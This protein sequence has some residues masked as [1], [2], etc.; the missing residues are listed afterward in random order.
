M[1]EQQ[2]KLHKYFHN[3]MIYFAMWAYAALAILYGIRHILSVL[4][5]GA[6]HLALDIILSVLLIGVG[7]ITIKAR[8]DLAAFRIIVIKELLG[9][10]IAAAVIFL[11]LHWVED[12]SGEDCYQNCIFKAVVFACWGIA[13]YRYYSTRRHLFK[14]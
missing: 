11:C 8:F 1:S 14:E 4:E 5:N 9:T 10:C 3:F 7:I 6:S 12:I 2:P 13:L